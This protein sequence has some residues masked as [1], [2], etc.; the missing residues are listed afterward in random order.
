[1]SE[2][3][4]RPIPGR[5]GF[6]ASSH[7][8]VKRC[9]RVVHVPETIYKGSPNRK[10]YLTT[11]FSLDGKHAS[12]R[13][14]DEVAKAFLGRRP[15]GMV[16]RHLDGDPQ[17]NRPENLRYGTH[18]ENMADRDRHGRTTRGEDRPNRKLSESDVERIVVLKGSATIKEIAEAFHVGNTAIRQIWGGHAWKHVSRLSPVLGKRP[19]YRAENCPPAVQGETSPRAKLTASDVQSIRMLEGVLSNRALARMFGVTGPTIGQIL[20]GVSWTHQ[21]FVY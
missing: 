19:R 10:G 16:I 15:E 1:M 21:P 4:W 12:V 18:L 6:E 20:R 13:V 5:P 9:A 7:G 2:E 17:N 11:V 8:R 14:H 3:E